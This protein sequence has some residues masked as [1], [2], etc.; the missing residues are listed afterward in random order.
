MAWTRN[1]TVFIS[2]IKSSDE[3]SANVVTGDNLVSP[4]ILQYSLFKCC[5]D[6]VIIRQDKDPISIKKETLLKIKTFL[7]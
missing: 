6:F 2:N 4:F 7:G 3:N 5:C 1:K